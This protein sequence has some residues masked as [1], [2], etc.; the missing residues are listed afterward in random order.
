MMDRHSRIIIAIKMSIILHS[1][2]SGS[3]LY[4]TSPEEP[5]LVVGRLCFKHSSEAVLLGKYQVQERT[6]REQ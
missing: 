5:S 3:V 1:S 4:L 2:V 6:V